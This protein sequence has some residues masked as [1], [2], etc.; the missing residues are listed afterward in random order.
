MTST[1]PAAFVAA[2]VA[3][4]P[5][6]DLRF[7]DEL[8]AIPGVETLHARDIP[9]TRARVEHVAIGPSGVWV[10][11]AHDAPGPVVRRDRRLFVGV[12]DRSDLLEAIKVP[13]DAVAAA[14]GALR[15]PISRALCFTRG[16][17]AAHHAPFML[18]GVWVGPSKPLCA[19]LAQ[20]GSLQTR[21]I[22]H[23][24]Q[25]LDALLPVAS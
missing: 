25:L 9:G 21:D 6:G 3:T 8:R 17:W 19:L 2:P 15:L 10:I 23:A 24:A 13:V 20:P 12:Q 7:A 22:M 14:L 18:N 11:E 1:D 16:D 5:V 4:A